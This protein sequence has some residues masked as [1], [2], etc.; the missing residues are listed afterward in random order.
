[1][2]SRWKGQLI[3]QG[4]SKWALEQRIWNRVQN[5]G[6]QVVRG[7][8]RHIAYGKNI[9]LGEP[10]S[11]NPGGS[12]LVQGQYWCLKEGNREFMRSKMRAY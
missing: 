5:G 12:V 10:K 11:K 6:P 1:M 9:P 3:N 2:N 8:G 7:I 4:S